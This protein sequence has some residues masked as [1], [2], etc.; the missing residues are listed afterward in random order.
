MAAGPAHTNATAEDAAELDP[1]PTSGFGLRRA[2]Q[3]YE[4]R[5]IVAALAAS[6]RG[7]KDVRD[8]QADSAASSPRSWEPEYEHRRDVPDSG[9]VEGGDRNQRR[10]RPGHRCPGCSSRHLPK[11]PSDDGKRAGFGAVKNLELALL[12][13]VDCCQSIDLVIGDDE[14]RV[15]HIK[16]LEHALFD[17]AVERQP[18]QSLDQQAGEIRAK[19]VVESRARRPTGFRRAELPIRPK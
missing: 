4:R 2:L 6:A 19:T 18:G 13:A 3:E 14:S 16:R 7:C 11:A 8:R 9:S 1:T 10:S 15:D 5:I 17:R 12:D